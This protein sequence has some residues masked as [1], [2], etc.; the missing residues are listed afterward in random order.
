MTIHAYGP[1][2]PPN[3]GATILLKALTEK[4][5]ADGA[6]SDRILNHTESALGI[7]ATFGTAGTT[8]A[9][10]TR[11]HAAAV[12]RRV[13]GLTIVHDAVGIA[14]CEIEM[15]GEVVERFELKWMFE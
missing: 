4:L 11:V 3:P 15:A 12:L 2:G 1:P 8:G 5:S 14:G 9:G 6:G 7:S 10:V 13:W